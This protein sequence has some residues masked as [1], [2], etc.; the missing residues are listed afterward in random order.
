MMENTKRSKG[1]YAAILPC[2]LWGMAFPAIKLGYG[3][4]GIGASDVGGQLLF[5]GIRFFFAGVLAWCI[6][7][8][9]YRRALIPHRTSVKKILMLSMFQTF[10]QYMFFYVGLAH[11]TGVK[12]SIITA[13]NV[14]F[15]VIISSLILGMEKSSAAKWT[16]VAVGFLGVIIINLSAGL[17]YDFTFTGEGFMIIS[18]LSSAISSIL[19]KKYTKDEPAFTL[20]AF[21][22][23]V[24]GAL[25][26]IV[27]MSINYANSGALHGFSIDREDYIKAVLILLWLSGISA[28]AYSIWGILLNRHEVSRITVFGF[29]IPVFGTIFSMLLL[30]ETTG[31]SPMRVIIS[32]ILVSAGT[33]LVQKNP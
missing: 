29:L 9:I 25:L 6:G 5:A 27:G 2:A 1:V 26:S 15:A 3:V 14:F 24:G 20:S 28:V 30:H 12:S 31:F 7:S 17:G 4:Y 18:S 11:T 21:Q 8:V 16:G 13:S 32:L 23:M 33:M 19:I 10:I 22:F